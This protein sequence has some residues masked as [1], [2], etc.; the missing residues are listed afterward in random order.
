MA[1]EEVAAALRARLAAGD[2]AIVRGAPAPAAGKAKG[3]AQGPLAR[4]LAAMREVARRSGGGAM[5]DGV[6]LP[7]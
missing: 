1:G 3:S 4:L 7:P 5:S 2:L 6:L